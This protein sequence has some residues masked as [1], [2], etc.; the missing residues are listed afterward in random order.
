[1]Q[2]LTNKVYSKKNV[3]S[4]KKVTVTFFATYN[5]SSQKTKK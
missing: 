3:A 1:M 5:I 4:S 2:A